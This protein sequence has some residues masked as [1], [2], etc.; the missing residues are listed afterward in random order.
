LVSIERTSPHPASRRLPRVLHLLAA[1]G[2]LCALAAPREARALPLVTL[3]ASVR[4]LYGAAT[5][6]ADLNAYGPGLGLRAGVTLP[7]SFYLG[8]SLDYFFGESD[9]IGGVDIS[10]STFQVLGNAGYDFVLG[11]L[12][13]RPNLGFGLSQTEVELEVALGDEDASEGNFALSPGVEAMIGLGLL[14][15]GGELRYNKV[16][17]D[18][19]DAVIVG[20]G[21]GLSI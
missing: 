20:I 7:A 17:A 8:A 2:G 18:D 3:S 5:G 6:D 12:T 11:P 1:A 4:G 16:F 15:V 10:A 9:S 14:N 21:L 13:L 19:S